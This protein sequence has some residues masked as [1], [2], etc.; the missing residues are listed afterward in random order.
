MREQSIVVGDVMTRRPTVIVNTASMRAALAVMR[1]LDVRH[2]PVVNADHELV[3]ML[4]DR[5][6]RGLPYPM[7]AVSDLGGNQRP[8]LDEPV[9]SIMSSDVLFVGPY[10]P[11]VDTIETILEG[12]VGAVPV[13]NAENRLVGIVSYVDILRAYH[14]ELTS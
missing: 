11:L 2:L 8:G 4:S 14:R 10:D 7:Q 12:R 3:G 9:T 6:L 13:V 5:D 1:E